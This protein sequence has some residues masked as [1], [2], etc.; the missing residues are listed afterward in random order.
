LSLLAA[1][2]WLGGLG[3]ISSSSSSSTVVVPYSCL[4]SPLCAVP[5]AACNTTRRGCWLLIDNDQRSG[6]RYR[7]ED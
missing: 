2:D 1:V 3:F 5:T 4:L 7:I 6:K